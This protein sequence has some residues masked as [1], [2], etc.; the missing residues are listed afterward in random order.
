MNARVGCIV[1]AAGSGARYG[2][3]VSKLA[4][5]LGGRPLLQYAID[6]A[7]SSHATSCTLV[8]GAR[9]AEVLV[10]VDTRRCQVLVNGAWQTGLAASLRCGLAAHPYDDGCILMLGDQPFVSTTDLDRLINAFTR[11]RRA[12]VALR[13]A[14]IWGAPVIFPHADFAK[15]ARLR[16]DRG[17]KGYAE[18]QRRRLRF[19]EAT[20][21]NAFADVDSASDLRRLAPQFKSEPRSSEIR[22]SQLP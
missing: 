4:A 19:L 22:Q 11:D 16:G 3:R 12:I 13:S 18:T 17:A 6:A 20:D 2:A 7:C 21:E 1:L 14:A 15:L 5:Q 10:S 9:A 8:V